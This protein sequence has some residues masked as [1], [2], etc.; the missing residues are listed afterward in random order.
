MSLLSS[1]FVLFF[2]VTVAVYYLLPK[3]KNQWLVLLAASYVFYFFSD[4]KYFAFLLLT[5]FTTWFAALRIEKR[6]LASKEEVKAHKETWSKEQKKVFKEAESKK[7]RR[8][9]VLTLLLN[10][11]VLFLL[12]YAGILAGVVGN[13][14]G[15]SQVTVRWL[16][17]LGISF[18]TFQAMG[19]IIDVYR[20]E[21]KAERNFG[22]LAL[23][24]S[25]FPQ[26]IQGP[27]SKYD[28]LA[29]QLYAEHGISFTRI[30]HGCELALW[31]LFKKLV[32]ANRAAIAIQTVT[33]VPEEY[34]GTTLGFVVLLYALQLYADFSAGIDIARAV[35]Q[36]LGIDMIQNFRQPYF[37]T[38][39][40]DYWNRWHISLGAWMKNY[41]F[42]PIALSKR[43][44]RFTKAVKASRF[45]GTKVGAHIANVLPGTVA[46]LI[47]FLIVGIW[48]GA[49]WR[50]I[51][52]GLWNGGIIMLSILLKP[53]FEG[54]NRLLH[55][56]VASP[57]HRVF[58]ILRTFFL[59]CI[60]NITDLAR[61]GKDCFFWIRSIFCEQD[62]FRGWREIAENLGLTFADYNVLL[63]CTALLYAVGILHEKSPQGSLRVSLDNCRF[64]TR[65]MVIFLGVLATII[66]GVYGPGFSAAEF[67]Y[68]QF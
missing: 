26:L 8:I 20:G 52:Y 4:W 3:K 41:V 63:L 66:L 53:A 28:Q 23:F 37:A 49:G 65:W 16:L 62:L 1:S 32:I 19:Y 42:Y 11:G 48:H 33:G 22:K 10:F 9:L 36:V 29:D 47:V 2:A 51:L 34:S 25:F 14:F 44:N 56:P 43:A 27:I 12:K 35:A 50:Y 54:A 30:K 38:S 45:G 18:Y 57:E 15:L 5:T 24:V 31:G 7:T 40:T 58:Q 64:I 59:V 17:P 46:S 61:G 13:W 55:V 6:N 68:M 39:L 67:A 60:G 21:V